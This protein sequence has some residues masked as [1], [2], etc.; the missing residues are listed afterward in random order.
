MYVV[1]AEV[2]GKVVQGITHDQEQ[3]KRFLTNST[4]TK[5]DVHDSGKGPYFFVFR[6]MMYY[7]KGT[8]SDALAFMRKEY[9]H[10]SVD[11]VEIIPVSEWLA[12]EAEQKER[13]TWNT[14]TAD[15]LSAEIAD[16]EAHLIDLREKLSQVGVRRLENPVEKW[17]SQFRGR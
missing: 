3:A 16:L 9:A 5:V 7:Y 14:S 8:Y 4:A 6:P 13:A 2:N 1:R 12:Y 11:P 15:T 10:Q 17:V